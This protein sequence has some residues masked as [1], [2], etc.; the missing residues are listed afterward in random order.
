MKSWARMNSI[1]RLTLNA[2]L[3]T[4][5]MASYSV[6]S[7]PSLTQEDKLAEHFAANEV[8]DIVYRYGA[9]YRQLIMDRIEFDQESLRQTCIV[10]MRLAE[11]GELES[12]TAPELESNQACKVVINAVRKV[13]RFPMPKN[14][15]VVER[16][17]WV[18]I[19]FAY[20]Q[21]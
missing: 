20:R 7:E 21:R 2:L 16:L 10:E 13:G 11:N 18:S 6:S 17:R 12:I 5:G 8:N 14:R 1:R 9:I 3:L 19:D 15:K 4:I